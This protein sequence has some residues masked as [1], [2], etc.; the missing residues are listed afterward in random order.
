MIF[1]LYLAYKFQI[2]KSLEKKNYYSHI[3]TRDRITEC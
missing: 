2:F 1:L 3:F